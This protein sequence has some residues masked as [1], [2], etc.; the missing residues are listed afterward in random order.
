M[1]P[2]TQPSHYPIQSDK[3][4]TTTI[5]HYTYMAIIYYC[6]VIAALFALPQNMPP[7]HQRTSDYGARTNHPTTFDCNPPFKGPL[8]LDEMASPDYF[9]RRIRGYYL[10]HER[11]KER[12]YNDDD[13]TSQI[14]LDPSAST[15]TIIKSI[16]EHMARKDAPVDVKEVAESTEFYLRIRKRLISAA[17]RGLNS[18]MNDDETKTTIAIKDLCSGHG[19]TGMLFVACNPPRGKS[20]DRICA[21]LVDQSKPKSH[22]VLKEIISEVCPW[23]AGDSIKFVSSQMKNFAMSTSDI[24][25]SASIV[26]STH[27]C[28]SLTDDV[29]K[30]ATESEASAVAVMPCCYTGTDSGVPYGLRRMLGV[31][32]SADIGRSFYLQDNQYHVDFA[33]VPKVITP[34]NR[35]IIAERRKVVQSF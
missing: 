24:E 34:M 15:T 29:L 13:I 20:N 10:C 17:R 8:V 11:L 32:L 26:I 4:M 6:A 18:K 28:G 12:I 23:V 19:L 31:S 27:A 35:I 7:L 30:Y 3:S 2:I 14:Q 22:D 1:S 5:D 25:H 21:V 9:R 33:S 16:I